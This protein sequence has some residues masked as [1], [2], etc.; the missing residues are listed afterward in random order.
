MYLIGT[1]DKQPKT[2]SIFR[3]KM[4]EVNQ[5]RVTQISLYGFRGLQKFRMLLFMVF[6]LAYLVILSGNCLIIILVS[7]VHQLKSQMFL[8]LK[9]LAMSDVLLATTVLPLA[10]H[11]IIKEEGSAQGEEITLAAC[12]IQ[13][14]CFCVFSYF[15]SF[16]ISAMAYDRYLAICNPLRYPVLMNSHVCHQ[17]ISGL[18]IL[19]VTIESSQIIVVCQLNFCSS[20]S[21]DHFFCD[22]VPVVN[23][24]T[25]DT[26][27]LMMLDIVLSIVTICLPFVFILTTYLCILVTI[28]KISTAQG[29]KK[30]FSTCGSHLTTV[31]S[32]YTALIIV[33]MVPSN[34]SSANMNKYRSLLYVSRQKVKGSG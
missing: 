12:I 24:S 26:S 29:R 17:L 7:T 25:S 16:L 20:N 27:A 13:L 2:L 11:I 8:F 15:Q 32:Y 34:E 9:Y 5:T 30:A 28:L 14:Y 18:W 31:F 3:P 10:L 33:Y 22:Y 6:L 4:C 19:A 1:V 23:L 21:I